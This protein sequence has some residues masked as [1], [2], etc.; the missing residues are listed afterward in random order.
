MASLPEQILD[1]LTQSAE[2]ELDAL[3]IRVRE[4]N[5]TVREAQVRGALF[6]LLSTHQIEIGKDQ[7]L[8]LSRALACK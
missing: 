2:V 8:K 7:K 3:V 4:K 6:P 5:P 1:I